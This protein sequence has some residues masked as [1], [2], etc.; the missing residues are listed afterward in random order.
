MRPALAAPSP[1]SSHGI[2]KGKKNEPLYLSGTGQESSAA[3]IKILSSPV[4]GTYHS[5][6]ATHSLFEKE[7]QINR[8]GWSFH[9]FWERVQDR[10]LAAPKLVWGSAWSTPRM[11]GE[12]PWTSVSWHCV[13]EG[14]S[15]LLQGS[16]GGSGSST[17][18]LWVAE[19]TH[20][21]RGALGP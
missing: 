16:V 19:L 15:P 4:K 1:M 10:L 8:W 7:N 17:L 13:C 3:V 2:I 21:G 20:C 14:T 12:G 11:A 18:L 6:S 5:S 9:A